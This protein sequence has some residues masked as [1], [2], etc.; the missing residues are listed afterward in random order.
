MNDIGSKG[1]SPGS[2]CE[3]PP[4]VVGPVG[5]EAALEMAT[6]SADYHPY[7]FIPET[8]RAAG[9]PGLLLHSAWISGLVDAGVRQVAPNVTITSLKVIYHYQACRSDRLT[10]EIAAA[11]EQGEELERLSFGVFDGRRR[12]IADGVACVRTTAG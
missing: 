7:C 10:L 11:D 2:K 9:L 4:V 3:W 8:A 5:E 1:G 12:L 6:L